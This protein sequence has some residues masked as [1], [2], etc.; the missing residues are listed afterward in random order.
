MVHDHAPEVASAVHAAPVSV[1]VPVVGS[2][3]DVEL[4]VATDNCTLAVTP[5]LPVKVSVWLRVMLSA[6][7]EP[8]S[9]A[10]ARSGVV[11]AGNT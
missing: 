9:D 8:L 2:V 4:A 11:G 1:H 3:S 10:V 6:D 7:D 5:A